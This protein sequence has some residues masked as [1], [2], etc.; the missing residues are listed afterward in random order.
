[1]QNVNDSSVTKCP[2]KKQRAFILKNIKDYTNAYYIK[3]II[4]KYN[5]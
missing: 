3:I 5:I 1:M 4:L 2:L